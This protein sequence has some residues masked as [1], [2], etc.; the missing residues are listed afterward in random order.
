MKGESMKTIV[1]GVACIIVGLLLSVKIELWTG[2]C[3]A[4]YY[5]KVF[6]PEYI[7]E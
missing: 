7:Q 1:G 3:T 6:H 2:R 4:Y 5:D